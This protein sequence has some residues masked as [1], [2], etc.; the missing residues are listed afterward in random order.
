MPLATRCGVPKSR[1]VGVGGP[2]PRNPE[3]LTLRWMKPPALSRGSGACCACSPR[4]G[5]DSA[6]RNCE[7]LPFRP[8]GHNIGANNRDESSWK[9]LAISNCYVCGQRAFHRPTGRHP[10]GFP[11]RI[12]GPKGAATHPTRIPQHITF[13]LWPAPPANRGRS[14]PASCGSP[15]RHS[16][17]PVGSS[18]TRRWP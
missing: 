1:H 8:N 13:P 7:G 18:S 4:C 2:L 12:K 9:I 17:R 16:A 11:C 14:C 10:F 15:Q 5:T 6:S 3:G